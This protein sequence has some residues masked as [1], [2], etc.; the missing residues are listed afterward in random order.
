MINPPRKTM[1]TFRIPLAMWRSANAREDKK[2]TRTQKIHN[3]AVATN[4]SPTRITE[5]VVGRDERSNAKFRRDSDA[6]S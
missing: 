2:K 3:G 6:Q 1:L 5:P 4:T